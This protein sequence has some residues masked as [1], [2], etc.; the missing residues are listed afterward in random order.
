MLHKL[1]NI[2]NIVITNV[3]DVAKLLSIDKLFKII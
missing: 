3:T 1:L 2:N